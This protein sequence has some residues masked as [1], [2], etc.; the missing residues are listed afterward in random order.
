MAFTASS[1]IGQV[2]K[3]KP[4]AKEI[5]AKHAGQPIDDAQLSMAMGMSIQQVAGFVGWSQEKIE[6]LVKDLNEL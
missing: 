1:T 5:L 6:A 2:F 4:N 3:E